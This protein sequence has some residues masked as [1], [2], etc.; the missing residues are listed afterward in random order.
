MKIKCLSSLLAFVIVLS[1]TLTSY[2]MSDDALTLSTA[3]YRINSDTRLTGTYEGTRTPVE[4]YGSATITLENTNISVSGATG[5]GIRINSTADTTIVLLGENYISSS[6]AIGIISNSNIVFAGN[7]SLTVTGATQSVYVDGR[8]TIGSGVSITNG[9]TGKALSISEATTIPLELD[10]ENSAIANQPLTRPQDIP[11]EE[12]Q[13]ALVTDTRVMVDGVEV[14]FECY[15]ISGSNYFKLRDLAMA[16]NGS[17]A[18]FSVEWNADANLISLT[19]GE[20]YEPTGTEFAVKN[21]KNEIAVRSSSQVLV[22]RTEISP[23]A[24]NIEGSNF[25]KLRDI[26]DEL[27]F[28][29]EWDEENRIILISTQ[30]TE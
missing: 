7:G 23:T 6:D 8:I 4:I 20:S 14:A 11:F 25:Y 17:A 9:N 1:S 24:Y 13:D 22:N 27:N 26:G 30:I 21:M 19:G 5:Y 16:L 29:V 2:A 3:P 18:S 15:N 10:P 12:L 28:S